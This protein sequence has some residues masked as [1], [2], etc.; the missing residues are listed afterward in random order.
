MIALKVIVLK[1]IVLKVI[2]L[3][4]IVLG[5]GRPPCI[6]RC[7]ARYR[8]RRLAVGDALANPVRSERKQ[9]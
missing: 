6:R 9:P 4:V 7:G 1:V 5:I 3:K 2:V 8:G